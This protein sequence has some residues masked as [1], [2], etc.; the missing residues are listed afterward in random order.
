MVNS[1]KNDLLNH[2]SFMYMYGHI[3]LLISITQEIILILKV[4]VLW[5]SYDYMCHQ[6]SVLLHS[7]FTSCKHHK[8]G[9]FYW[10]FKVAELWKR[11]RND[12]F[13]PQQCWRTCNAKHTPL[14]HTQLLGEGW[15]ISSVSYPPTFSADSDT[16][17]HFIGL[18]VQ[19]ILMHR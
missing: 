1:N 18:Q 5:V 6:Y 7:L 10:K 14:S 4:A 17:K 15:L 9:R 11:L 13:L 2:C 8:L 12:A 19:E 3:C 16:W